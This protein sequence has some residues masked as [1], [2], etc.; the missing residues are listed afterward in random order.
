MPESTFPSPAHF[1]TGMRLLASAFGK[2]GARGFKLASLLL[3]AGVDM[4]EQMMD[5]I[6]QS[7]NAGTDEKHDGI[8][9]W[10]VTF[11]EQEDKFPDYPE[12]EEGG[13]LFIFDPPQRVEEVEEEEEGDGKKKDDK[14]GDKKKDDKK[15]GKDG[16]ED[17]EEPPALPVS[18]FVLKMQACTEK[19]CQVCL[20]AEKL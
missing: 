8:S 3:L 17:D 6:R 11:R 7:C 9:K 20:S 4:R 16:E 18:E 12:E 5:K 13:S 2:C 10:F 1:G 14:K 15:K 19:F